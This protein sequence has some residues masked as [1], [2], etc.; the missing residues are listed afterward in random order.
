MSLLSATKSLFWPTEDSAS[1][2]Y[3]IINALRPGMATVP[4]AMLLCISSPYAR[5]GALWNACRQHFGKD[6]PVL[7]WKAPTWATNPTVDRAVINAAYQ[8]DAASASAEYGAEF[9]KDIESFISR[10]A[11]ERCVIPDRT[12]LPRLPGTIYHGFTDPSGGS[13]DSMTLAI[14]HHERGLAVLDLV[15]ERRPPFSPAEVTRLFG[16]LLGLE[17]RTQRGGRDLID[18]APMRH[19]DLANAAAGALLAAKKKPYDGPLV[20]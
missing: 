9:R 1:P 19:D 17:R 11:L 8:A 13:Q 3:E 4:G 12:E 16:Q 14:S 5:R 6:S 20:E 7:V 2:D 18:H 15:R 10:K